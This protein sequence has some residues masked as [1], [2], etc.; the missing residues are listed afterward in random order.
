MQYFAFAA[1][2]SKFIFGVDACHVR[3][4]PNLTSCCL[5]GRNLSAPWYAE[6]KQSKPDN[7]FHSAR[8]QQ[9]AASATSARQ[10]VGL[11]LTRPRQRRH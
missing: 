1:G 9:L 3:Y 2:H 6:Q 7:P 11:P 5:Q 4:A 10:G 8:T